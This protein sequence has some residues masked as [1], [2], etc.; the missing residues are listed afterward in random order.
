MAAE[1][2]AAG[3]RC[4]FDGAPRAATGG[5]CAITELA[6]AA[7]SEAAAEDGEEDANA[8]VADDE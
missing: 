5:M 7:A 2:R 4:D 8:M 3:T 6:P 1:E